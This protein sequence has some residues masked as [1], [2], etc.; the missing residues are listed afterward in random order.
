VGSGAEVKGQESREVP[1]S[2]CAL[3]AALP[4]DNHHRVYHDTEYGFAVDSDN[5]L[6]GRLLLEI[7]QAGLSWDIILKKQAHFRRAYHD[8]D[9]AKVASYG[10]GDV[11]RLMS[12]VGIVRNRLK[13]NAAIYNA[14]QILCL[15]RDHGSFRAWLALQGELSLENWVRLFKKTFKFTGG[16]ITREFLMGTAH[17][18]G[19]HVEGCPI[20]AKLNGVGAAVEGQ[21]GASRA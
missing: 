1:N 19:A 4:E 8:Y 21:E 2:Y 13:V 3:V 9:I 14:Q 12:D 7:N 6:F 17:L 11:D 18:P 15:Q 20:H 10:A 5:A 16:E